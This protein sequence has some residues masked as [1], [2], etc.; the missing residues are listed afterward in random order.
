M[1]EKMKIHELEQKAREHIATSKTSIVEATK[2]LRYLEK[3]S[4]YKEN[5]RYK[6]EMFKVYLEDQFGIRYGTYQ[7]RVRALQFEKEMGSYGVGLVA[8]II[9]TCGNL[10]ANRVFNDVRNLEETKKNPVSRE[11]IDQIIEKHQ[12]PKRMAIIKKDHTDWRAMY[13]AEANAHEETKMRLREANQRIKELEEQINK[14]KVTASIVPKIR[15][16]M[17][18][19]PSVQ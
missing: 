2:I 3:T 12:D 15:E 18:N 10:G 13:Q 11:K 7:E 5:T 14:L 17:E 1:Y 9:R 4:R 16:I 6:N 8:K 19:R